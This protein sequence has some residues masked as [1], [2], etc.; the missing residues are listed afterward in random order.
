MKKIKFTKS[1][2]DLFKKM[3][4]ALVYL[5]GSHAEGVSGELSDIDIGIVFKRPDKYKGKTLEPYNK[6][7]KVFSCV[8]EKEKGEVDVVFL[9]FTP[10]SVQLRAAQNGAVLY[11][12]AKGAHY[13]Y[14]EDIMKRHADFSY[15]ISLKHAAVLERV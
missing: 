14:L 12:R 8:F 13:G 4:I 11:K 1:Q 2:K 9:Q 3:G 7:Y 6:L 5:F 15:F 10:L